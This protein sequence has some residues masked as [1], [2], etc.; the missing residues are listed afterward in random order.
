MIFAYVQCQKAKYEKNMT[1]GLTTY[2]LKTF[3][4]Y[5]DFKKL[6]NRMGE[7]ICFLCSIQ[8]FKI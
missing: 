1:V 6:R 4:G 2:K 5:Q 3:I 8:K 7:N